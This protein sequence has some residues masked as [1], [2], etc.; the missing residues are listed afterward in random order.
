M[1]IQQ[2]ADVISHTRKMILRMGVKALRMDDV[3]Q[4]TH[5]S[6]RTLYE[7]FGDK[8][9]LLFLAVK[10]HFDVFESNNA[11][12]ATDAPNIL[13]AM[14]IIMD[15]I[16]E[17]A[18][19]NWQIR[20]SLRRFYPNIANRLLSDQSD[21]KRKVVAQSIKIGVKQGYIM[22]HINIELTMNMFSYI[23]LGV[24]ENNEMI[25]IPKEMHVEDAFHEV[26]TNYMRGISTAKGIAAIDEYLAKQ[27]I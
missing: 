8:E 17:N 5:I 26:L 27:K 10:E 7:T 13:V 16:R 12:A 1:D 4:A 3:A 15:E 18:E 6:K 20:N 25:S 11:K 21:E 24:S 23:A 19:I 22:S 9:E 14:L 2:R